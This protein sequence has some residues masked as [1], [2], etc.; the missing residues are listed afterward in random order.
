MNNR[1]IKLIWD[2]KGTEAEKIAA[3]HEQHLKEYIAAEDLQIAI[4]GHKT[5]SPLHSIAYLVVPESDM[6][7]IRDLLKPHRGE[8]YTDI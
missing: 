8:V 5:L 2:F 3:H 7:K 1:Q 4:T 6:L